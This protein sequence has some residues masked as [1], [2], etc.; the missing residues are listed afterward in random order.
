[1]VQYCFSVA[2]VVFGV[3][4]PR[5]LTIGE[6][7]RPFMIPWRQ[8]DVLYRFLPGGPSGLNLVFKGDDTEIYSDG[9]RFFHAFACP[10]GGKYMTCRQSRELYH[11]YY[12]QGTERPGQYHFENQIALAENFLDF[13]AFYLHSS[14]VSLDGR[15]IIFTAAS[16]TGKST[17]AALWEKFLGAE[18][19]NGDRTVIRRE[20]GGWNCYGS[21]YA[22]S[23]EIYKNE[24]TPLSAIIV[25]AQG[26][27]NRLIRLSPREAFVCLYRETV[28][29]PWSRD[30]MEAMAALLEQA[31]LERPVYRLTC[32][33]DR[34]AVE[35]VY[36]A[37]FPARE[38][39]KP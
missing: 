31:V 24:S 8:P 5:A 36:R 10:G 32:R 6:N 38:E 23:S 37:V 12:P 4:A 35:L 14:C 16:G 34:E 9:E 27:E 3:E 26:P 29:N 33:P 25:L 17:Q 1:M 19:L 15:G 13:N 11:I 7:M 30:Y 39:G 2:S 20:N 21:P 18:T 28:Q 22:G